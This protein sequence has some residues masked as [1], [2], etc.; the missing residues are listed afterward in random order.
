MKKKIIFFIQAHFSKR[1]YDRYGI[2]TLINN[3]FE[4]EVWDFVSFLANDVYQEATSQDPI[5]WNGYRIFKKKKEAIS[6]I[7]G[8][9]QS[10]IIF[11]FLSY[12]FRSLAIYR[13]ISKRKLFYCEQAFA[14]PITALSP[15]Q[16]LAKK[17]A[18]F[19]I[20][21]L[22]MRIF[23]IIPSGILGVKPADLSLVEAEKFL[24]TEAPISTEGKILW[25][26]NFDYDLFLKTNGTTLAIKKDKGVFLD[27]YLPLHSDSIYS[28]IKPILG[29]EEYYAALRRFFDYLEDK[30]K[31]KV[32]IAAH[33][34]SHYEDMPNLFGGREVVIGKTIELVKDAGFV[35]VHN[36]T[37]I[38]F[39]VLFKRPLLFL[40]SDK[41]IESHNKGLIEEP[42]VTWLASFFGKKAHNL[43][44]PIQVELDKELVIN[45]EAYRSY[46][47]YY[48]KK[49][50]SEELPYWQIFSNYVKKKYA[51]A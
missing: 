49:D 43:D 24:P 40:T 46:K 34:R 42:S 6:A 2:E 50:G 20:K 7:F 17:I 32:I 36:S 33:P 10:C 18:N 21:K 3:G 41:I 45:E 37:A 30:F 5:K 11:S 1:D 4:V 39:A 15:K 35:I 29:P 47:N 48:I 28:G 16:K 13:A 8:L 12:S 44:H 22:F 51:Q 26:H 19:T 31:V 25:A 23:R 27:Q 38:N 14:L 9:N